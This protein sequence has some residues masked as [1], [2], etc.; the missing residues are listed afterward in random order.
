VTERASSRYVIYGEVNELLTAIRGSEVPAISTIV[1]RF[2]SSNYVILDKL[3]AQ[4]TLNNSIVSSS[5]EHLSI[6]GGRVRNSGSS[7]VRKYRDDG[8]FIVGGIW[9]QTRGYHST[10]SPLKETS[11]RPSKETLPAGLAELDKL[12]IECN[13]DPHFLFKNIRPIIADPGFLI[14]AYSLIK[15]KPGNMTPGVDKETLDKVNLGYFE[16]MGREIGSGCFKFKPARNIDILTP[17]GGTRPLS[18]AS[19]RDKIVQ[20]AMKIILEAVFEPHFSKFS[21]GFRPGRG[22]H[23]AIFQARGL[24]MEVN[25]FIEAD[26]SKCFDT[27]P[28]NLMIEEVKKRIKDQV[29]IDLIYKS[30]KAGYVEPSGAFKV[31]QVGSPQG[32]IISPIL[33]NTLLNL[34]DEWLC[35]YSGKFHKGIRKK[36][37]PAYTKLVRDMGN[38]LP[39][40]RKSIRAFIHLNKIRPLIGNDPNFKRMTYVR[41][42]DDFI[43]GVCGSFKDC[44]TIRNDLATF[45]KE[46][47]GLELSLTKTL[48]T[49]ATQKKAHFLGF[50]VFITPYNK[51]QL[52][53]STRRDGSVRLT[54]QTSRP[55]MLAPI[56]KIVAKLESKG[57]CKNGMIGTPTRVG[58][59]I[60][61]S[62]PMIIGH[63]IAIGRGLINYYS[64]ADN[65]TRLK[66]RVAYILKYSCA[67]TFASKLKLYT[68]KKVFRKFGYNLKV[69]EEVKGEN[70]VVAQFED[71]VL[72]GIK[73]G[74]RLDITDYD[75]LSMIDLAAK[76]YPRSRKLFEGECN[77]CGSKDKLEV[78]HVKHLRKLGQRD[79]KPDYMNNLMR[80]MNRKQVLLCQA[81]HIKVHQGKH[82]GPGL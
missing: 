61:L 76:A 34:L 58:R 43:I 50:D 72:T 55:Q 66:A 18:I 49:P 17:K 9:R 46:R 30:F 47:L 7:E 19:P 44:L 38:K 4:T 81:C 31:P 23:T 67:L 78:H 79:G 33:C 82:I 37:N 63:Y 1:S 68:V 13:K 54:A 14:Y 64:C 16:T 69:T 80:A 39:S 57:Y 11:Q 41:Y 6:T 26:I 71:K 35:D 74:F 21:H 65:F 59:L 3:G 60:H 45:L 8:G 20:S 25:W 27:L 70:K 15:S 52:V 32:S 36:A 62:L 77:V 42:A 5:P 56:R 10:A 53:R 73:P 75:P 29:F 51:R 24:F 40:E 12:I 28:Q 22:N 48:I 2:C